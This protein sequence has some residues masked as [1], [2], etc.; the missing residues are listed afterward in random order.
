M[1]VLVLQVN[2][3][4]SGL[5]AAITLSNRV[6]LPLLR[7]GGCLSQNTE[8]KAKASLGADVTAKDST[9]VEGDADE[10]GKSFSLVLPL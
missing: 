8:I 5:S 10:S 9:G 7:S 6:F 1:W 2:S 3:G 4:I